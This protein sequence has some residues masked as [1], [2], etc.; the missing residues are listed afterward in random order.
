MT[1]VCC[2]EWL[3]ARVRVVLRGVCGRVHLVNVFGESFSFLWSHDVL[4]GS[5]V[6]VMADA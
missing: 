3:C 4:V 6:G 5:H 2:V 1:Y